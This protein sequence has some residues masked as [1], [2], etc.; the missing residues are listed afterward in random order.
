[1]SNMPNKQ[2]IYYT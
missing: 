2:T 1:M